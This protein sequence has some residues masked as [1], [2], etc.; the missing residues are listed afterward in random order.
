MGL[1]NSR[2]GRRTALRN[3]G[4]GAFGLTQLPAVVKGDNTVEITVLARGDEPVITKRVSREWY[5]HEKHV[6]SVAEDAKAELLNSPGIKAVGIGAGQT[7]AGGRPGGHLRVYAD[8]QASGVSVPET[9]QRLP[10]ERIDHGE[11]H[12][13]TSCNCNNQEYSY[14]PGGVRIETDKGTESA[15]ASSGCKVSFGSDGEEDYL[16]TVAHAFSCNPDE[17]EV[18]VRQ[19]PDDEP[20]GYLDTDA[21]NPA[22]FDPVEDWAAISLDSDGSADGYS[23]S[24]ADHSGE[25]AGRVTKDGLA[26]HMCSEDDPETVYKQGYRTCDDEGCIVDRDKTSSNPECTGLSSGFVEANN[27][28]VEQGDSGGPLFQK[29]TFNSCQYFGIIGIIS[30]GPDNATNH[31]TPSRQPATN[32]IT[33][34]S[35]YYLHDEYD[36]W[37]DHSSSCW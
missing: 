21:S 18:E 26:D 25:V 35:G 10:I 22:H 1:E 17:D 34:M 11:Y 2:I 7:R 13:F 12:T 20:F 31:C 15:T 19:G 29:F 32:D 14:I 37:F 24:I 23:S 8:A 16:L 27:I 4:A 9:Y 6:E 33:C 3:I 30:H 36:I 5:E 28:H